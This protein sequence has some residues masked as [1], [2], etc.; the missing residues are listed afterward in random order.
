MLGADSELSAAAGVEWGAISRLRWRLNRLIRQRLLIEHVDAPLCHFILRFAITRQRVAHHPSELEAC[1]FVRHLRWVERARTGPVREVL[2]VE[3]SGPV[4]VKGLFE[5]VI[6][7]LSLSQFGVAAGE[8]HA[9]KRVLFHDLVG[10][11]RLKVGGFGGDTCG[12]IP[13][14]LP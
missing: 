3:C 10:G 11:A 4:K 1:P 5:G 13:F 7:G 9:D 2:G 6:R 12:L 14:C 8:D